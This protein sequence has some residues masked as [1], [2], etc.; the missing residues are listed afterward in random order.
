MPAADKV[1]ASRIGYDL[2]CRD[3]RLDPLLYLG[4]RKQHPPSTRQAPEAN[5]RS[6]T[7]DLP[8]KTAAGMLLAE[9]NDVSDR[10]IHHHIKSPLAFIKVDPS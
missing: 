1:V 8:L 2:V 6:K 5:V 3:D 7:Y 10:Q 9:T 4:A